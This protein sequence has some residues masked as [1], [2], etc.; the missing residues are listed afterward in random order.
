M[1]L[2]LDHFLKSVSL[3]ILTAIEAKLRYVKKEDVHLCGAYI[4]Q[5]V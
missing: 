2:Y 3:T 5:N 1:K 4:I